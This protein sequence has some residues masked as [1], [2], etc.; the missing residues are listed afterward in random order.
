M[1][2]TASVSPHARAHGSYFQGGKPPPR[3]RASTPPPGRRRRENALNVEVEVVKDTE[4][5]ERAR[6]VSCHEKITRL[7]DLTSQ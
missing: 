3:V 2:P 4:E 6:G 5:F 7:G 1:D